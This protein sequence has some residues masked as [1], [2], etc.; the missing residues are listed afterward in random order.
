MRS[1]AVKTNKKTPCEAGDGT[2][3]YEVL[4]FAQDDTLYRVTNDYGE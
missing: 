4:R 2:S 3:G 1:L